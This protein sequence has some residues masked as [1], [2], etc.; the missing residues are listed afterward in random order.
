[1]FAPG[2][3][4]VYGRTGVCRVE[5]IEQRDG[6]AFYRLSPLYQTCAIS[7]PVQGKVF[8]RPV[9]TRA[10]AEAL[11]DRIPTVEAPPV[12]CSALRELTGRYQA[13]IT[14]HEAAEVL[15]LTMSIYAKKQKLLREKR[16]FGAVDER[17]L[18]EGEA[19]LFGELAVALDIAP[20]AVPAYIQARLERSRR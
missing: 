5:A 20:E 6:Q 8:M 12:E 13:A 15:A 1:M 7:T 17:F 10:E 19:L 11:I 18:R 3:L 4:I 9:L 14:S 16:K 2:D